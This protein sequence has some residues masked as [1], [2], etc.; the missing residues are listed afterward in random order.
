MNFNMYASVFTRVR[1]IF[2]QQPPERCFQFTR[3][4]KWPECFSLPQHHVIKIKKKRP[5]VLRIH[6]VKHRPADLVTSPWSERGLE[7]SLPASHSRLSHREYPTWR[8][9][10]H[11]EPRAGPARGLRAAGETP[12]SAWRT[13]LMQHARG[14]GRAACRP[15]T[16]LRHG[17][18]GALLLETATA[19]GLGFGLPRPG[20]QVS[21]R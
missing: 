19:V 16:A 7:L 20:S 21:A 14:A 18:S 6:P 15:A 10:D 8:L 3:S 1:H 12:T 9:Q 2:N 17:F 5:K 13:V 11:A 4:P